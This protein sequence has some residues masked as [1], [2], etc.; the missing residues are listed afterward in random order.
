MTGSGSAPPTGGRVAFVLKGYPRLSETF[1]AQE[2][3]ALEQRGLDIQIVSLRHPT[4][5]ARHPVHGQIRAPVLYLPEYLKDEPRRVLAAWRRARRLQ[6]YAAARRAWLADLVRDPTPNRI[7]RFGQALVVAAELPQ[8]IGHLHAHF[9]HT[10]ASAARYAAVMRGLPWSVSAHAKDIW[11]IPA[12]EK[13]DKLAS[14]QW[15]VTCTEDGRRHLAELTPSRDRVV[16]SY[17][18][19]DL[20]RF[21]PPQPRSA[22]GDGS[23]PT[24]PVTLLSVGRAVEKKGYDDL[25]AALA[26]LPGDLAWRFVHIGGGVLAKRLKRRSHRLGLEERIEWRGARPQPDVL[27]AYREADLFVLAAKIGKD[28]DRDGLPNVL[29]EAQS[30]RLACVATRLPGIAELVEDG[31]TGVLAPP[32]NPRALATALEALIRDP[33]QRSRLGAAGEERVRRDFD[34]KSGI[35]VLA[36]LFGLPEQRP[37]PVLTAPLAAAE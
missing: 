24:R 32:G 15:A 13:R 7:R 27:A 4:D 17:H 16:L 19:L 25:V 2:I 29:M 23:D 22:G 11:T 5:R 34:M 28:S 10:P 6:G 12:W 35:A 21:V 3:W 30:Q 31:R 1:I 9:L 26:L 33:A 14:A 20:D 18:G 8:D 37:V 36:A